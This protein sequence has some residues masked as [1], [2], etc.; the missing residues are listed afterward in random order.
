MKQLMP[1][2]EEAVDKLKKRTKDFLV[3]TGNET[4]VFQAPTGAGK[5]FMATKYMEEIVREI[6][7]D[8]CFLWVSIGKG[9]LH[10]QS[11][12]AVKREIS[13]EMKCSLLEDEF[14]VQEKI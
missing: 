14:L 4:I 6:P 13:D 2:Q 11:M 1:Y 9:E 7:D 8:V 3:E 5:T 10:K 12:K